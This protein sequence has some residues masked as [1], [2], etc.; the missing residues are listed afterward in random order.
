MLGIFMLEELGRRRRADIFA[1][2]RLGQQRHRPAILRPYLSRSIRPETMEDEAE[3]GSRA[4]LNG[5]A[6]LAVAIFGRPAERQRI[7]A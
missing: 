2:H 3:L 5:I 7:A 4:A 1:D 6:A